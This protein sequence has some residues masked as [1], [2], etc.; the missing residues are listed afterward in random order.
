ML[1]EASVWKFLVADSL[2]ELLPRCTGKFCL[3]H[4]FE[5]MQ[6]LYPNIWK[7]KD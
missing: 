5:S 6:N 7:N 1:V 4:I 2:V 3:L